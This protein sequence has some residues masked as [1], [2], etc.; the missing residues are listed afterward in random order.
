NPGARSRAHYRARHARRAA[1]ARS[2]ICVAVPAELA[3]GVLAAGSRAAGGNCYVG[4]ARERGTVTCLTKL[5]IPQVS[6]SAAQLS[7]ARWFD[8]PAVYARL[9]CDWLFAI[10][11]R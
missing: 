8:R 2:K 9:R 11:R 1:C 7:G 3:R 4:I 10:R 5:A 6:A